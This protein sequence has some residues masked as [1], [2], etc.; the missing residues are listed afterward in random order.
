MSVSGA[1]P[2]LSES[3]RFAAYGRKPT[4]VA[5]NLEDVISRDSSLVNR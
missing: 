2:E 1:R 4:A 5:D 3:F